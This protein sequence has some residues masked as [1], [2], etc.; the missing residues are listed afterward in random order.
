MIQLSTP[1]NYADPRGTR[2]PTEE[3]AA[4]SIALTQVDS[5]SKAG[6]AAEVGAPA[7]LGVIEQMLGGSMADQ[8]ICRA[9][10]AHR[11]EREEPFVFMPVDIRNKS[12]L[13][14]SL[15]SYVQGELLEADNA[16]ACSGCAAKARHA[17]RS[18]LW[19]RGL[20]PNFKWNLLPLSCCHC[21]APR[22]LCAALS[23]LRKPHAVRSGCCS[24]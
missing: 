17:R 20:R 24:G 4:W 3:Q 5:A 12:G 10:G 9:N 19:R 21:P 7:P 16:W 1:H 18:E 22:C 11:S 23:A 8:I 15:G 13:L 2:C 6:A 14:E